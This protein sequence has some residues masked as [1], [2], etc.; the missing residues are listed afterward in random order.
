M[1]FEPELLAHAVQLLFEN[2]L[3]DYP[4]E[5]PHQV[6]KNGELLPRQGKHM[7]ADANIAADGVEREVASL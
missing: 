1:A 6:L 4:A 3:R 5:A 2:H 7:L